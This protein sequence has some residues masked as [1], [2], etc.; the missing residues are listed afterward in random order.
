MTLP[1]LK[2]HR[3]QPRSVIVLPFPHMKTKIQIAV[4]LCI[5]ALGARAQSPSQA[6]SGR[7]LLISDIHLDPLADTAIVKQL[8]SAPLDRWAAILQSSQQ[9]LSSY[10]ADSNYSLFSSAL[11]AAAAQGRFD[12]VIFTGDALRHDFQKAFLAAGGTASQYPVFAAKTEVFVTGELQR[13][14][15]VPVLVALGNNDSDCGDYAI[16]ANSPFL[17]ALAPHLPV[18]VK[19]AEARTTFELGGFF[20]VPN[21]VVANHDFIV[22]NSVFWSTSYSSCTPNQGDPG[23]AELDWLS[24][25]LYSARILHHTVTLVMHIPP[26]MNAYSSSQ[27]GKCNNA[28]PMWQDQYSTRFLALMQTYSDIVQFVFAGHTHMDDF[29]VSGGD[30]PW[31]PIRITPAISPLFKNNPGFSVLSY[32]LKTAMPTDLKTFF[33][34]LSSSTAQ[35]VE[36]YQFSVA[37]TGSAFDASGIA[38]VVQGIRTGGPALGVYEKYYAGS[39]PSPITSSNWPFYSC[40]QSQ[41][42]EADYGNCVCSTST[43]PSKE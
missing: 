16:P 1:C 41:F 30:K 39:T 4:V 37:Y 34:P 23:G 40:A 7:A 8:I 21:P 15:G 5:V 32:D 18:L 11:K 20:S 10:G 2:M 28:V 42:T 13:K 35:W 43:Q 22:L 3:S 38:K 24:W 9:P 36:E 33:I 6:H 25:K 14:F 19:S 27:T 12:Y 31:L 26:G 17:A 29:H